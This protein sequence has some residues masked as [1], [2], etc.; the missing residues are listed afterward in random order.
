MITVTVDPEAPEPPS[1]QLRSQIAAAIVR[2]DLQE[3]AQLPTVRQLAHDLGLAPNTVAKAYRLLEEE[4]LV[5]GAGRRGTRVAA[6]V[7]RSQEER[8]RLLTE[9]ARRYLD[10]ATRL[11]ASAAEATA[12]LV[13]LGGEVSDPD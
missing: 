2:R 11:G 8:R 12:L 7:R 6:G 9:A 1:E 10:E 4:G 13:D 5:V 3:G